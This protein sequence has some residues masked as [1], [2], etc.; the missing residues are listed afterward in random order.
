MHINHRP[1]SDRLAAFP[2]LGLATLP[3]PLE[4]MKRLTAH[5][6]GPRLWVK[7]EDATG[8]GFGGNKLRKLDYVLHEALSNSADAIVSGGVVQSNS[9]RQVAAG[10]GK[11]G[12]AC[13]P[14]GYHRPLEPPTPGKKNSGKTPLH[15]PFGSP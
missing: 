13:H 1:L 3:T 14:S 8:L 4:P 11:P 2:R 5:L 6:G 7:R 9:Q 15:R 12:I 10:A